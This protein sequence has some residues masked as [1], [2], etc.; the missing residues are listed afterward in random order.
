[1]V[2]MTSVCLYASMS[3][4]SYVCNAISFESLKVK[5]VHFWSASTSAGHTG[6]VHIYEGHRVKVKGTA[7]KMQNFLFRQCR[8][9]SGITP[10]L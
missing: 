4:C 6:Q 5:K 3:V 1:M 8:I 2:S 10:V 9:S 7:G